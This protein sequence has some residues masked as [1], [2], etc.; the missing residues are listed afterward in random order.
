VETDDNKKEDKS[1]EKGQD[2]LTKAEALKEEETK[3][4]LE[5]KLES[6]QIIE[7]EDQELSDEFEELIM[8]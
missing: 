4:E 5:V 3:D 8:A 7:D 1:K 2:T 6:A